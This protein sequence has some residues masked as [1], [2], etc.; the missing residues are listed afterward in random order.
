MSNNHLGS[1]FQQIMWWTASEKHHMA[2]RTH[3]N[4][5]GYIWLI[6]KVFREKK[7]AISNA[8]IHLVHV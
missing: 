1:L 3:E 5:H 4:D 2:T 6:Q 7:Y 8:V